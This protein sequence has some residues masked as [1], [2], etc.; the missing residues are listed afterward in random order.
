MAPNDC[1]DQ[2]YLSTA[3][4][5]EYGTHIGY[6]LTFVVL[7]IVN[8]FELS[9]LKVYKVLLCHIRQFRIARFRSHKIIYARKKSAGG[10]L[11]GQD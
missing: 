8:G 10:Y 4:L 1:P 3:K 9:I 2:I 5:S 6:Q 11:I 7:P